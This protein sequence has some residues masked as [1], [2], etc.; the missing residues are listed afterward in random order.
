MALQQAHGDTDGAVNLLQV[1]MLMKMQFEYI[2]SDDCRTAL[3]H[4]Q[5]KVDRAAEW[6]LEKSTTISKRRV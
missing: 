2:T 5:N 1:D 4:C 6:L 3:A